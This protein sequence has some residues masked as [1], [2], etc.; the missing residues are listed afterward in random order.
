M[1]RLQHINLRFI[2][3]GHDRV[4]LFISQT[5]ALQYTIT[6]QHLE[7]QHLLYGK[8]E[9]LDSIDLHQGES[10]AYP[11]PLQIKNSGLMYNN[12]WFNVTMTTWKTQT[13]TPLNGSV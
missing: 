5:L 12:Y 10:A 8:H 2:Q 1:N 9:Q 7:Q 11:V 6:K 13:S 4:A 3:H